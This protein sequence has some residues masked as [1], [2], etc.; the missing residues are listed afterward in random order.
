MKVKTTLLCDGCGAEG[1]STEDRDLPATAVTLN[2]L[3]QLGWKVKV[4]TLG[5]EYYCNKC[6]YGIDRQKGSKS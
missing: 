4:S 5:R 2:S 3:T 1:A 6:V